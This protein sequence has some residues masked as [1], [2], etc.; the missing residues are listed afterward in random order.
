L[1]QQLLAQQQGASGGGGGGGA[2]ASQ[3]AVNMQQ[4][5][6]HPMMAAQVASMGGFPQSS[7]Y[8]QPGSV[9]SMYGQAP[10]TGM[11]G[12][13]QDKNNMM[14]GMGGAMGGGVMS[15]RGGGQGVP[16]MTANG[17]MNDQNPNQLYGGPVKLKQLPRKKP[18]DKP[19][20][21]LSAYNIFFKEERQRILKAIPD[22]DAEEAAAAAAAKEVADDS[23]KRKAQDG[24]D[25]DA[26]GEKDQTADSADGKTANDNDDSKPDEEESATKK[27]KLEGTEEKSNDAAASDKD[28]ATGD[29][30]KD[31]TSTTVPDTEGK[32]DDKEIESEGK[33]DAAES[34]TAAKDDPDKAEDSKSVIN[35]K[36]KVPHGKIGFESLA[37]TIG[38]RWKEIDEE[39]LVYYKKRADVDMKR[40]KAE[41]EVFLAKQREVSEKKMEES[42]MYAEAI[43]REAL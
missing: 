41:M 7:A 12:G 28:E 43:R 17:R 9:G 29:K 5:M 16:G 30:E 18:K 26:D 10:G 31:E 2:P 39:K 23:K 8:G 37:K 20:R 40:Y 27:I 36:G 6:Q 34:A 15:A 32:K 4:Y 21:P 11:P 25:D 19:K 14:G 13:G 3:S 42:M 35:K 22:K 1:L 33:S 38:R 24:E